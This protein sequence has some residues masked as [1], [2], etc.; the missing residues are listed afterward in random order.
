M[1]E[2]KK[3]SQDKAL[4]SWKK[5]IKSTSCIHRLDGA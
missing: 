5:P 2:T 4:S 3:F 1:P